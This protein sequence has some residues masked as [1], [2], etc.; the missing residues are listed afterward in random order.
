MATP[1]MNITGSLLEAINEYEILIDNEMSS[2]YDGGAIFESNL[3]GTVIS[4]SLAIGELRRRYMTAGSLSYRWTDVQIVP[5]DGFTFIKM[6][7]RNF[8][9]SR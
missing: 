7:N 3:S 6:R 9:Y 5:G 1:S 8:P 4:G 2:S